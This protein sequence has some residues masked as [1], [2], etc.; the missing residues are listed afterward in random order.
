MASHLATN[1]PAEP[2][3]EQLRI[4]LLGPPGATWAG[5]PLAIPRRQ[6]RALLYRLAAQ[7]APVPREQLCYLF[8]PDEPDATARPVR[9]ALIS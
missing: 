7:A 9:I 2:A 1:P 3:A 4:R 6:T 8:W 5:A